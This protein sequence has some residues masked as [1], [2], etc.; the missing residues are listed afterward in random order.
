ML[1]EHV[2]IPVL[3]ICFVAVL[4]F[5]AI[6]MDRLRRKVGR[7]S[8]LFSLTP[9]FRALQTA[10]FYLFVLLVFVLAIIFLVIKY[11][12]SLA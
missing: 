8:S 6:V 1:I 3:F 12:R 9:S 5:A 10:E 4:I 2:V 7:S 11:A